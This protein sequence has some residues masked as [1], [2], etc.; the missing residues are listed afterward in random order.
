MPDGYRVDR[1]SLAL[2]NRNVSATGG[3]FTVESGIKDDKV[4]ITIT[5]RY[6]EPR[7]AAEHWTDMLKVIDAAA[8][9]NSATLVLEKK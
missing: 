8:A 7:L 4:T 3:D 9:W 2:L 6:K 5:K 1:K